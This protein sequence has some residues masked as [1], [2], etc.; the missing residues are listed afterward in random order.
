MSAAGPR[1]VVVDDD[2]DV[3]HMLVRIFEAAGLATVAVEN[4]VQGVEQV[5][6]HD[7]L[8]VSI[9]VT[10]PGVDGIEATRLIRAAGADTHIIMITASRDETDV[11]LGLA[12]GADE[13]VYKPLRV[14]ELRARIDAVVRRASDPLADAAARP[15]VVSSEPEPEPG[16]DA[17]TGERVPTYH[18]QDQYA[19]AIGYAH[20][21]GLAAQSAPEPPVRTDIPAFLVHA[22]LIVDPS[23][24]IVQLGGRTIA[25]DGVEMML[26]VMLMQSEGLT[27]S[28]AELAMMLRGGP[29][30]RVP[31]H[32][33]AVIDNHIASLRRKIGDAGARARYIEPV[34]PIGYRMVAD[35]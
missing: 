25:L 28:R 34:E 2:P 16:L 20:A 35:G 31:A 14:R 19:H 32:E 33:N 5:L 8:I 22:D 26:L 1:A 13:Y 4:G 17:A 15:V 21:A 7:P 24:G 29:K 10:M 30:H 27:R 23:R 11:V 6:A 9:D 12:A 3:R 18:A